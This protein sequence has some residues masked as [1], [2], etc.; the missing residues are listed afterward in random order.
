MVPDIAAMERGEMAVTE[1]PIGDR[2]EPRP[3]AGPL[4]S[5][6]IV[7][8]NVCRAVDAVMFVHAKDSE[9]VGCFINSMS[10]GVQTVYGIWHLPNGSVQIICRYPKVDEKY[11]MIVS[12]DI[13]AKAMVNYL[14]KS[15]NEKLE[16]ILIGAIWPRLIIAPKGNCTVSDQ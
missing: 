15:N 2:G 6:I 3:P 14:V 1:S 9:A 11:D 5:R 8:E 4:N 10:F 16:R 7:D 12:K 13:C